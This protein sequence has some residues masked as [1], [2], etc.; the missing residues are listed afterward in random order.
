MPIRVNLLVE[1]KMA[2]A[3]RRRDPVKWAIYV[4]I[5][6]VVLALVWS[7]SLQLKAMIVKRDLDQVQGS[8]QMRANEYAQVVLNQ[9]K[10][11]EINQKLEALQS[12]TT[13]RFLQGNL[14][15][16]LQHA[17]LN[18]VQLT[19]IRVDQSYF[20]VPGTESVTNSGRVIFGRP[21]TETERIVVSLEALDSSANPGDQVN[22][23]KD[24][25]AEQPFF[26]TLLDPT[27][28]IQLVSVSPQQIGSDGKPYVLFSIG[29]KLADQTR[30]EVR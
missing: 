21:S 26:K 22:R 7:S 3:R 4:G 6:F 25:I 16:A 28:G 13:N 24:V 29:C 23:F 20:N 2:E 11:A 17:T 19:R 8:I 15:E 30:E 14:L 12:L 9:Q 27:N 1:A 10:V 5:F 18:G